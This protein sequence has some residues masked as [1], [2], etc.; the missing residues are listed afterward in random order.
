M[1]NADDG[2]NGKTNQNKPVTDSTNK[3]N[4]QYVWAKVIEGNGDDLG[5]T[6]AFDSDGSVFVGGYFYGTADFNY[7]TETDY[8]TS[9][10]DEGGFITK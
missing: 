4:L 9:S 10:V 8:H 5:L 6:T 2:N 1:I 7:G 3:L